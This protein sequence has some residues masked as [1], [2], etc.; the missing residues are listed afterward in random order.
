MNSNLKRA[1]SIASNARRRIEIFSRE[2]DKFKREREQN[3][4]CTPL[5]FVDLLWKS[6]CGTPNINTSLLAQLP[7]TVPSTWRPVE[8]IKYLPSSIAPT[9][10]SPIIGVKIDGILYGISEP[11]GTTST[12]TTTTT[13]QLQ[14]KKREIEFIRFDSTEGKRLFWHSAAHILGAALES[15]FG[16]QALLTDGPAISEDQIECGFFYELHLSR[17]S[18][19]IED[20]RIL[21]STLPLLESAAKKLSP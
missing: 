7:S 17:N 13:T 4:L 1:F 9:P 5:T 15:E 19:Q 14:G 18:N 16:D 11:I 8:A 20:P 2:Q 12:S 21:E 6:S 10:S 3:D